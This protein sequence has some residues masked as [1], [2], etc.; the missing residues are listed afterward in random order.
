MAVPKRKTSQASRNSRSSAN[1]HLE[2]P[3]LAECPHCHELK[4]SHIVCPKCGYYNGEQVVAKK[5]KK[6]AK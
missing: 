2:K 6:A 4:A 5:E 1:E 3:T